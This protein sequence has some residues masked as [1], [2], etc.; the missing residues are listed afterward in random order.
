MTTYTAK[1]GQVENSWVLV[2]A[3][4]KVLGRLASQIAMRLR[5]V[6]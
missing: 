4:N 6:A 1:A 2:D 3:Q 5:P